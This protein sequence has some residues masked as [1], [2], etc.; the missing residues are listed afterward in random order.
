MTIYER[1]LEFV[2][3]GST[4][5]LGS[6]RASIEFLKLLGARVGAGFHV[7]G[8]P[9]SRATATLAMRLGIILVSLEE[10]T[11]PIEV[12]VDGELVFSKKQL[13][14]HPKKAE[15][16]ELLHARIAAS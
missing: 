3:D 8:V 10:A 4:I 9:T 14:R 13:G 11:I 2:R 16:A 6:G 12:T 5:G 15:L 1:A 7:R